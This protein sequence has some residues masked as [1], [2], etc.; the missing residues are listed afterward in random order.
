VAW[1]ANGWPIFE[2]RLIT[3]QRHTLLARKANGGLVGQQLTSS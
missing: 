2:F 3:R 1:L